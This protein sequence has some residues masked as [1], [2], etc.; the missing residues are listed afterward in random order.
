M[1]TFTRIALLSLVFLSCKKETSVPAEHVKSD[2]RVM[3]VGVDTSY[4]KV[5]TARQQ[6]PV[7]TAEDSYLKV[8]YL[9]YYNGQHVV[10][11]T[12]KQNCDA[13][14]V[15]SYDGLKVTAVTPN[16]KNN[17]TE[18]QVKAKKTETF[19]FS[20]TSKGGKIK[21]KARTI[22]NWSCDP[23]WLTIDVSADM[24]P[25]KFTTST[26]RYQ[27]GFVIVSWSVENPDEVDAYYIQK[28]IDKVWVTIM[29]VKA[30]SKTSYSVNI[31][32]Q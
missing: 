9:G 4:T 2:Y 25:I 1:K 23:E 20:S 12:N 6:A 24:L 8:V 5:M 27:N 15:T 16:R 28:W 30:D 10:Q 13:D 3:A 17:L 21:F 18:N 31:W 29:T 11:V 14:F 19:Y 7:T 32:E 26:T 22:C